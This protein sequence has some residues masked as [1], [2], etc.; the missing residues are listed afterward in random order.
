MEYKK[1]LL[2]LF[3]MTNQ[4][5]AHAQIRLRGTVIDEKRQGIEAAV[6]VLKAA[7]DSAFVK[8][9]TTDSVGNFSFNL[10]AG[11]YSLHI[12][13]LGYKKYQHEF[14]LIK[15]NVLTDIQLFPDTIETEE[16]LITA[17]KSR[18]LIKRINGKLHVNVAQSYLAD[19]GNALDVFR[20]IPGITVDS[21]GK[22]AL[23]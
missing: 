11:A 10:P 22:I 7:A 6:V 23:S 3:F 16:V 5:A 12:S 18:P 14:N 13:F 17:H 20:H 19:I 15:D 4:L 1:T 2:L 21:H 8:T 9:Y